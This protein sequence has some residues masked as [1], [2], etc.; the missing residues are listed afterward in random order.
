MWYAAVTSTA[1][2]V[3]M[4]SVHLALSVIT[5]AAQAVLHALSTARLVML[6]DVLNVKMITL[7]QRVLVQRE[8]QARRLV[9]REQAIQ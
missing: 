4:G 9:C 2:L 7:L 5:L 6:L 8:R 3:L 1:S